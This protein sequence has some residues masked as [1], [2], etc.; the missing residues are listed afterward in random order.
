MP[1]PKRR[2]PLPPLGEYALHSPAAIC[3]RP[4]HSVSKSD[5]LFSRWLKGAGLP[6]T[7]R[8]TDIL[9]P[10]ERQYLP[11]VTMLLAPRLQDEEKELLSRYVT[12]LVLKHAY[13]FVR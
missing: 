3:H 4:P 13:S 6:K 5:P 10:K 2:N 8:K 1:L 7:S 11:H 9:G 12:Q